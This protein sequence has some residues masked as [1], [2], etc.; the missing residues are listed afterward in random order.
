MRIIAPSSL[1]TLACSFAA[2]GSLYACSSGTPAPSRDAGSD[3]SENDGATGD[4]G[5]AEAGDDASDAGTVTLATDGGAAIS[6]FAF[7]HNYWDWEDWN[8]DS[9]TGLTGTEQPV[10]AL[11]LN[12]LRAGGDNNDTNTPALF[13]DDHIDAFVTYCRTVGAEPILQVPLV[14]NSIDGGAS[15]PDTAAAMV[16]YANVTKNYGIKYWEIGNEPDLYSTQFDAGFPVQTVADYCTQF[17][18]YVTAMKAANAAAPDGG[19]P[20]QFLGPELGYKY[21]SGTNDWLSP[22]LDMCGSYVDIVSVHRYPFSGATTSAPRALNDVTTFRS[23]VAS[24]RSIVAAHARP[25]TPLA[26]TEANL[27][28]DYDTSSYTDASALAAPGTFPAALWTADVMGASLEANL[29]TLAFWNIG[30]LSG[31]GSVLGFLVD[32]SPVPAYYAEQMILGELQRQCHRP[33]R[34]TVGLFGLREP[35]PGGGVDRRRRHQQESDDQPDDARRR[36]SDAAVV[37]LPLAVDHPGSDPRRADGGDARR[38]L[39]GRRG[40]RR[41]GPRDDPVVLDTVRA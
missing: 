34:C 1:A 16:T 32:D 6:P 4:A 17:A 41:R 24:V 23:V 25:G 11:H 38:P 22:F 20:L 10:Q 2:A 39:H 19:V 8:N 7:G 27:S 13:D 15:T 36:R 21:T 28:Y 35:R 9:V 5:I 37:R 14:A 29:W 30:E 3:A 40:R 33:L 26:I 31:T 18:A 12:V